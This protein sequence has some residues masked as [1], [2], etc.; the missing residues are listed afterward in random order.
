MNLKEIANNLKQQAT[1]PTYNKDIFA[2]D[3]EMIDI[4]DLEVFEHKY[5]I[6]TESNENS[7]KETLLLVNDNIPYLCKATTTA[8]NGESQ[9]SLSVQELTYNGLQ[10]FSTKLNNDDYETLQNFLISQSDLELAKNKIEA[11]T[12]DIIKL[13]EYNS[14]YDNLSLSF[15]DSDKSYFITFNKSGL[16]RKVIIKSLESNGIIKS[17][18]G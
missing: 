13:A 3:K 2:N 4:N 16:V 8:Y 12:E 14:K 9:T 6:D 11:T 7:L 17:V 10:F 1:N 5:L 15:K 18:L